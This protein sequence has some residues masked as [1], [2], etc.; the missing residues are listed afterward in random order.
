MMNKIKY[1]I[2]VLI[3]AVGLSSCEKDGGE[4]VID[5]RVGAVP[6]FTLNTDY[7]TILNLNTLSTGENIEF[8]FNLDIAQGNVES[9]DII[10]F[11]DTADGQTYGPV[12]LE[13][14]ITDFPSD[15]VFSTDELITAF[16]ELN[17]SEDFSLA[18]QL[19][20]SA[21]LYLEDGTELALMDEDGRLYGSDVHT[22]TIYNAALYYS[23]GCPLNG[24][25]LGDYRLTVEGSGGFGT[26]T[27]TEIVT[28]EETSQT[29]RTFTI[30]YIPQAIAGYSVDV[31]IEFICDNVSIPV[32][33]TGLSCPGA[34][35]TVSFGSQDD[36]TTIDPN[37]ESG[38]SIQIVDIITDGGCGASSGDVTLTFEKI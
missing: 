16:S 1:I 7:P 25:F 30:G 37:D 20:I 17:G 11:Y 23:I 32:V 27:N 12:T 22:S 36:G 9:A 31:T 3:L 5:L 14:G 29:E 21:K 8:G 19:R 26:F 6:D 38:F 18:D 15:Y 4:S 35:N 28:F 34:S 10:A 13:S 33:V 2:T 24:K